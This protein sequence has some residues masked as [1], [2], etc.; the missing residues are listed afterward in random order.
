MATT[1]SAEVT[2]DT[3]F[4]VH[5][6]WKDKLVTIRLKHGEDVFKLADKFCEFLEQNGI[7]YEKEVC[8]Y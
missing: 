7:E 3:P 2:S 5:F 8:K 1:K 4:G 6:V